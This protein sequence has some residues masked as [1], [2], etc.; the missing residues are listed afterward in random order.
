[1]AATK[2]TTKAKKATPETK[3]IAQV[4]GYVI[5][6]KRSG[7]YFIKTSKGRT[8]NGMDKTKILL[9]AKLVQAGL[10]K[11]KEEAAAPSA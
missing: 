10:P 11:A 8:V 1:M 4:K 9:E 5:T 7:R 3:S 2:K 6:Q